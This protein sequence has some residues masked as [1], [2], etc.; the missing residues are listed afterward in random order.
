MSVLATVSFEASG[1]LEYTVSPL[2][3]SYTATSAVSVLTYSAMF[4]F[5]AARLYPGTAL[6]VSSSGVKSCP[7]IYSSGAFSMLL[8]TL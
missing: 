2:R 1:G 7:S 3:L 5:W 8:Y 4:P 6:S